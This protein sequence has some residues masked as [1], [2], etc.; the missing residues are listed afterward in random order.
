MSILVIGGDKLGNI[1]DYLRGNGFETINHI[2]GRKKGD[3][4]L[5]IPV[6]TD[7]VLV[8][9]DFIGHQLSKTIKG[10]VKENDT[11]IIY[12]RRSISY[13]DQNIK[14]FLKNNQ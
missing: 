9:T 5:D 13:L 8:L 10:R 6:N 12:S 11:N 7:L 2:T 4:K 3:L 1:K 14:Q